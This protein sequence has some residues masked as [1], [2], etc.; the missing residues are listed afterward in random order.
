MAQFR[1]HNRVTSRVSLVFTLLLAGVFLWLAFRGVDWAEMLVT[2]R[3]TRLTY[4]LLAIVTI[5]ASFYLRGVRWGLLIDAVQATPLTMFWGIAVGYLGNAFLPARAGEIIRAMLIGR[6][7]GVSRSYV[8]ATA[9]AERIMDVMALVTLS[10]ILLSLLD[11]VPTWILAATQA[12]TFVGLIA[13]IAL[14]AVPRLKR[15]FDG[16]LDMLPVPDRLR[17]RA[18]TLLEHFLLGLR[19]FQRPRRALGFTALT[20]AIWLLEAMVV[21]EM[22]WALDLRLGLSAALLLLT[23]LGLAA[24]VPSTPGVVGIYQFVAVTVL[25]LFGLSQAQAL[26]YIIGFQLVVYFTTTVWGLLGLWRLNASVR[27]LIQA[28]VLTVESRAVEKV[29]P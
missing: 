11:G 25:A 10:M 26:V 16:M 24:T 28:P 18:S 2:A 7:V 12:M 14:L 20:A 1:L 5:T 27:S 6:C 3:K 22:A 21:V 19:S 4:L 13:M 29:Q 9:I 17:P 15:L 23:A 8:L